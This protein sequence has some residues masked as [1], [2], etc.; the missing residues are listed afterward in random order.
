MR[1]ATGSARCCRSLLG[2]LAV[3]ALVSTRAMAGH[4][5]F[6]AGTDKVDLVLATS[7]SEPGEPTTSATRNRQQTVVYARSAA[8]RTSSSAGERR[9]IPLILGIG[10]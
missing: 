3:A 6:G 5:A 7:I 10:H 8:Q 1:C 9:P 4:V 2:G